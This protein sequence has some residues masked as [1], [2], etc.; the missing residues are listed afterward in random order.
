[1]TKTENVLVC[2]QVLALPLTACVIFRQVPNLPELQ[3]PH[4]LVRSGVY[5]MF[6]FLPDSSTW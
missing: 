5:Q 2:L 6:P 1:M 3:F 4:M